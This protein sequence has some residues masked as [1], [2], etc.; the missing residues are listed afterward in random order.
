MS[1]IISDLVSYSKKNIIHPVDVKR[2]YLDEKYE[3]LEETCRKMFLHI[4]LY[5]WH[6]RGGFRLMQRTNVA[7]HR[8]NS[9]N[10]LLLVPCRD[11][12]VTRS[13]NKIRMFWKIP[14]QGMDPRTGPVTL[15]WRQGTPVWSRQLTPRRI[16]QGTNSPLFF[17]WILLYPLRCGG[18]VFSNEEIKAKNASYHKKWGLKD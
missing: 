16:A 9:Q 13:W 10:K 6:L 18:G 2:E 3:M 5:C 15:T 11:I 8:K 17:A 7:S 4:V 1:I 12:F 14:P